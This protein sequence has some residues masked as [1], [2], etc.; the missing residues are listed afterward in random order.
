MNAFS[1]DSS[2]QECRFT[3]LI[4]LLRYRACNQPQQV[5]YKFVRHGDRETDKLT[6][7]ELDRQARKIAA[8][9]Q[10]LEMT[11]ERALLLYSPGLEFITAF[12]VVCMQE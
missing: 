5:A 2:G 1:N 3:N 12:L 8:S 6:Y 7:Q 10:S 4:D 9:L 11:G